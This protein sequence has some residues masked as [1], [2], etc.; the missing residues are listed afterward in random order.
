L[1]SIWW[2]GT[3]LFLGILEPYTSKMINKLNGKGAPAP[4]PSVD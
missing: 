4:E 1:G 3:G 2:P